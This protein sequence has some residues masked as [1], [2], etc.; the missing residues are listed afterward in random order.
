MFPR[1]IERRPS[2]GGDVPPEDDD[3]P[4]A[5]RLGTEAG[6]SPRRGLRRRGVRAPPVEGLRRLRQQGAQQAFDLCEAQ[7]DQLLLTPAEETP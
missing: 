5:I 4:A 6:G 1:L 7:I 2:D 3:L